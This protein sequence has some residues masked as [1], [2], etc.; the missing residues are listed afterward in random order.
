MEKNRSDSRIAELE[1]ERSVMY[2]RLS[3]TQ[4]AL[5]IQSGDARLAAEE[6]GRLRLELLNKQAYPLVSPLSPFS[7]VNGSIK[8]SS[9]ITPTLSG[10]IRASTMWNPVR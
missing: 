1:T 6:A 8:P 9:T 3:E 2:S 10:S 5:Q 4:T 7:T